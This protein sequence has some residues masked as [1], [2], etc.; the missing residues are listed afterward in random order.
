[1]A[2]SANEASQ[3]VTRK[4]DDAVGTSGKPATGGGAHTAEQS[5]ITDM[6]SGGASD[7]ERKDAWSEGGES[8][9]SPP[10]P[11]GASGGHSDRKASRGPQEDATVA[12]GGSKAER[13]AGA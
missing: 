8:G 11:G 2:R 9:R 10:T 13:E 3:T 5:A 4:P 6:G 7:A 12:A 1:M